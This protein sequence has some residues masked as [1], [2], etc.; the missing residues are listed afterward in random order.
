MVKIDQAKKKK[1]ALFPLLAWMGQ[2]YVILTFPY[3]IIYHNS[4]FSG[5]Q[6][7]E[8]G[9]MLKW[10]KECEHLLSQRKDIYVLLRAKKQF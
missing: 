6:K 8:D 10:A 5:M 7:W 2:F 1:D 4:Y 3:L 9:L